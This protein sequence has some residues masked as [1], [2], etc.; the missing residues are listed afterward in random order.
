MREKVKIRS[1]VGVRNP[2]PLAEAILLKKGF[3]DTHIDWR[4]VSAKTA[5]RYL[6]QAFNKPYRELFD[7]QFNSPLY[8]RLR[9]KGNQEGISP[10]SERVG[11]GVSPCTD[12]VVGW[13]RKDGWAYPPA[14]PPP[15]QGGP[16]GLEVMQGCAPDCYFIAALI[17]VARLSPSSLTGGNDPNVPDNNLYMFRNGLP[18][19]GSS[20]STVSAAK[21]LPV[22][23]GENL[24]FAHPT[25]GVSVWP[26]LYEKAYGVFRGL[27]RDQPDLSQ[28][29]TWS[30]LAALWEVWGASVDAR[31]VTAYPG[32]PPQKF[33]LVKLYRDICSKGGM[34]PSGGRPRKAMVA[35]TFH[36]GTLTPYGDA[37]TDDLIVGNHAYS[38]LGT[39][40]LGNG[41]GNCLIMRNP[42][43]FSTVTAPK[44]GTC[45]CS[46]GW[47]TDTF[48]ISQGNFAI[49]MDAFTRY[50]E[51]FAFTL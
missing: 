40:V 5:K 3:I 12:V 41:Y 15:P 11:S 6:E 39:A 47:S 49:T 2:Y 35:W 31:F 8:S 33:D 16:Y 1:N 29:G 46:P 26:S 42:Y 21:P 10:E 27:D 4:K 28:I 14:P 13:I 32:I 44:P 30:P 34:S 51:G 22:N 48:Q 37:Y 25:D 45:S 43:G 18:N 24:V 38:I 19:S 7:P 50:F 20:S 17:S 36:D 9:R 23:A